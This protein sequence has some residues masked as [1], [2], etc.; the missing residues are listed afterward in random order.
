MKYAPITPP[1]FQKLSGAE[2]LA[3]QV[4]RPQAPAR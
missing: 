2:L 3:G 1:R 4:D